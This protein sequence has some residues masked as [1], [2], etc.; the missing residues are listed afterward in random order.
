MIDIYKMHG[1]GNTFFL[2]DETKTAFISE[3]EKRKLTISLCKDGT[4]GVLFVEESE[5][6]DIK[7][8]IFN[9]D[10]S[11]P[12]MCGNGL[13]CFSRYVLEEYNK[14]ELIVETMHEHYTVSYVKDFYKTMVGI[15][16]GM[17]NVLQVNLDTLKTFDERHKPYT[18]KHFTVSNPHVVAFTDK[19]L[20]K[21]VLTTIGKDANESKDVFESGMNVNMI[22]KLKESSIYVQTY[23][24]GVGLTKSCGTGMT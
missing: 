3:E 15:K 5:Q 2:V 13:R 8:R 10:G 7:M 11:E 12:E 24:R 18:F 21:E 22:T 20:S 4:D 6:Y 1:T 9:S 19:V 14:N 23:E 16:V 17:K